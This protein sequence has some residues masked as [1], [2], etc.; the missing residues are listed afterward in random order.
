MII[1]RDSHLI[2]THHTRKQQRLA[3]TLFAPYQIHQKNDKKDNSTL[4]NNLSISPYSR[5][6]KYPPKTSNYS[7]NSPLQKKWKSFFRKKKSKL[8]NC[9]KKKTSKIM[10]EEE[11]TQKQEILRSRDLV[12]RCRHRK[13]SFQRRQMSISLERKPKRRLSH[14]IIR[15]T[16]KKMYRLKKEKKDTQKKKKKKIRLIINRS[17]NWVNSEPKKRIIKSTTNVLNGQAALKL[18]RKTFLRNRRNLKWSR[19]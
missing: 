4:N 16:Y 12:Q 9:K 2:K 8:K 13:S 6:N 19:Y 17:N 10:I 14:Q 5:N 15:R 7:R 1:K 11:I 3:P 18:K